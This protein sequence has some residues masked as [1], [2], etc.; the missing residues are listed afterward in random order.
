MIRI[1]CP[2]CGESSRVPGGAYNSVGY[3]EQV[4]LEMADRLPGGRLP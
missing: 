3:R 2:E 4:R 1:V